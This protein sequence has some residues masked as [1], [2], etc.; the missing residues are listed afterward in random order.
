[1]FRVVDCC[2]AELYECRMQSAECRIKVDSRTFG[3]GNLLFD[4]VNC[5]L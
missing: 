5:Y 2:L 4:N 1:M 3:Y